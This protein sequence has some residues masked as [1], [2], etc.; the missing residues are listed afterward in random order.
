VKELG[1]ASEV[2]WLP[3]GGF[4]FQYFEP[5]QNW[6]LSIESC[7]NRN[8]VSRTR[9]TFDPCLQGLKK[10]NHVYFKNSV[11]IRIKLVFLETLVSI[12]VLG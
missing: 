5:N 8:Q 6:V 1:G 4:G 2:S 12:L 9:L 7:W 11:R 3:H 10:W